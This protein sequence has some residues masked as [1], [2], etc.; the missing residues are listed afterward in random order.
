MY[1]TDAD[2]VLD[3]SGRRMYDHEVP[4]QLSGH[5]HRREHPP[6]RSRPRGHNHHL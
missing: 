4:V 3:G 5:S 6:C 2:D 1:I